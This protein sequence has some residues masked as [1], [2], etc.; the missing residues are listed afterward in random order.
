MLKS[1]LCT[2]HNI[3]IKLVAFISSPV[4]ML[5]INVCMLGLPFFITLITCGMHKDEYTLSFTHHTY[6]HV[7]INV[8]TLHTANIIRILYIHWKSNLVQN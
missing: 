8:Y 6:M 7:Y 5:L 3:A 4:C 2:S 1:H